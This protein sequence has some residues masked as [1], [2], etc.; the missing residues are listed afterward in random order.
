M[1]KNLFN[2]EK[3]STKEFWLSHIVILISTVF[4]VYLAAKAGLDTAIEFEEIQSDRNSYYLQKSLLDEFKDNTDQVIKMIKICDE[5]RYSIYF[6]KKNKSNL[7]LFVWEAMKD[8]SDTFEIP[9]TILTGI[10]RYYKSANPTLYAIENMSYGR[11]WN[12]SYFRKLP[13]LKKE[14]KEI[15]TK[16]I[17]IMEAEINRLKERLESKGVDF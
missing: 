7:D 14:T 3:N 2:V 10:R 11:M 9:S 13:P 1:K 8:S 5:Q 4:A 17:P 15:R 12:G 6:G 16:L